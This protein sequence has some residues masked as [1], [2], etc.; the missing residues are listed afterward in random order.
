V[1]V[2]F[3]L[4]GVGFFSLFANATT[5][6]QQQQQ[7]AHSFMALFLFFPSRPVFRMY[8]KMYSP[9]DH[10]YD[11]SPRPASNIDIVRVLAAVDT[12]KDLHEAI[13]RVVSQLAP[14]SRVKNGF[15]SS[16]EE[17]KKNFYLRVVLINVMFTSDKYPTYQH[18][19]SDVNVAKTWHEYL[20]DSHADGQPGGRWRKDINTALSWL[21]NAGQ[22]TLANQS[23]R[24]ICE[25]QFTLGVGVGVRGLMH[26]KTIIMR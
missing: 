20:H 26:G 10:R 6:Q 22:S 5:T 13:S 25:V 19:V 21:R 9:D 4:E 23:V 24:M 1:C 17:A 7:L 2:F 18:L 11:A 16:T 14:V 8:S 12:P 3:L 15:A